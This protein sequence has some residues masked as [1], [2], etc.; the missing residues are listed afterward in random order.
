MRVER[1]VLRWL[2]EGLKWLG[3]AHVP[4]VWKAGISLART[5]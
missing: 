1:E 2:L 4:V 5:R 3:I